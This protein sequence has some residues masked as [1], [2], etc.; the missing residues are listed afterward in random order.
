M[1][2]VCM[3]SIFEEAYINNGKNWMLVK[4]LGSGLAAY[5]FLDKAVCTLV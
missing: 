3:C 2:S 4:K 5:P 1:P